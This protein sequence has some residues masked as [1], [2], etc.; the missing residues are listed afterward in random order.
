MAVNRKNE[1]GALWL[2]LA[3]VVY[4]GPQLAVIAWAL[5]AR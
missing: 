1:I 2:V 5:M 3:L 4:F